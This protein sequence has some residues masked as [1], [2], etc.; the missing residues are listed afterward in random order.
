MIDS[1]KKGGWVSFFVV[2]GNYCV[3]MLFVMYGVCFGVEV[4]IYNIVV[5]YYVDYFKLLLKDVGFV[6]G[7]FGLFVLFVC[8]FGGWLFDKIVVCCSFDVC[9]MLLCVLIIGEGF[10]LIWFLYV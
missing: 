3:W 4:F 6:V 10:G 5:L 9:V 2:C 8:V 7:M 1:G